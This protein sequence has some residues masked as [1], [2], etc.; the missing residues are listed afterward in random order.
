MKKSIIFSILFVFLF[1]NYS[2]CQ[3]D[4]VK[5]AI[6]N[7]NKWSSDLDDYVTGGDPFSISEDQAGFVTS[8]VDNPEGFGTWMTSI[9]PAKYLG[10]RLKLSMNLKSEA[11]D[12]WSG[13]WMRVDGE[14]KSVLSF[15]NM[16]NRSL[17]GSRDWAMY[18]IVLDV[19]E[20]SVEIFYGVLLAGKGQILAKDLKLQIVDESV[21]ITDIN[22]LNQM[23]NYLYAGNYEKAIP[24]LEKNNQAD[25]DFKYNSLFYYVALM[26]T[27]QNDR[28]KIFIDDFVSKLKNENWIKKIALFLNNNIT[29]QALIE[30]SLSQDPK[31]DKE[32]K[33]EA[34]FYI[35][36]VHKFNKNAAQAKDFF[37]K[38]I[39]TERKDF[40]EY[41]L[42]KM[43]L[44]RYSI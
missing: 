21:A 42:S 41:K 15:D 10:K 34:Y 35:G 19:P 26:E 44:D 3:T 14:D 18:D 12:N 43:E 30:S 8:R 11:V 1:I 32:K 27:G 37:E 6:V 20:N 2:H 16:Q 25:G 24:F 28:A 31:T 4:Y 9:Q 23:Y 7:W 22:Y 13:M 33:C 17:K 29:E 40:V 39:A 38:S 5:K 36:M